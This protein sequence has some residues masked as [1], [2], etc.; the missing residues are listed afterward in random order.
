MFLFGDHTNLKCV[1]LPIYDFASCLFA[2]LVVSLCF[3]DLWCSSRVNSWT[4]FILNLHAAFRAIYPSLTIPTLVILSFSIC[5][6]W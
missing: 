3:S 5:K 4:S 2:F 1:F 6:A